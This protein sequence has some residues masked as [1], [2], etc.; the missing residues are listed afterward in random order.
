M[1]V[2]TFFFFFIGHP[3]IIVRSCDT[4]AHLGLGL[5]P[6]NMAY[7]IP[8]PSSQATLKP[9]ERTIFIN[10][11]YV[12][13]SRSHP[14]ICFPNK[15]VIVRSYYLSVAQQCLGSITTKHSYWSRNHFQ[16]HSHH[17]PLPP[18]HPLT[19]NDIGPPIA[20]TMEVIITSPLILG[21]KYE[22]LEEERGCWKSSGRNLELRVIESQ[23][24]RERNTKVGELLLGL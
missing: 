17:T 5:Q 4:Q 3:K 14:V 10:S 20:L 13:P 9:S 21:Y 7:T 8:K 6:N 19:I 11:Y 2:M 24:C 1:T 18:K 23:E 15:K 22:K 12:T 16:N